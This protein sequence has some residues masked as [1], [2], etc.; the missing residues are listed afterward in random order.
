MWKSDNPGARALR[1][2]IGFGIVAFIGL[3]ALT[4]INWFPAK[5][6]ANATAVVESCEDR[7]PIS[8]RGFGPHWACQA[9]ITDDETR[10]TWTDTVDMN[11]LSPADA[12][13]QERITWGY[14]G[15]RVGKSDNRVYRSPEGYSRGVNTLVIIVVGFPAFLMMLWYSAKAIVW[16]LSQEEQ[17]KFWTKIN[18]GTPEELA[19]TKQ[20]ERER[21]QASRERS[22]AIQAA[23]KKAKQERK[24]NS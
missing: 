24:S 19:A 7:G 6:T 14:S 22:A 15:G 8:R 2:I 1:V 17:R 23:R 3:S 11:V 4:V 20:R 21:R 10:E 9:T 18:K 16:G 13:K 5:T 12:G